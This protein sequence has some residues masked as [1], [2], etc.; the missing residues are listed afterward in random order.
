M[1]SSTGTTILVINDSFDIIS[2]LRSCNF[3]V[4]TVALDDTHDRHET[5]ANITE[6]A[7]MG[8]IV[9]LKGPGSTAEI[10]NST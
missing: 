1:A 5:I 6:G 4:R 10:A 7:V 2:T 3:Q 8:A 9:G